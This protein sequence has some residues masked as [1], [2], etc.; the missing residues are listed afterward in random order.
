MNQPTSSF[1][2]N[3]NL[4]PYT[5]GVKA[6]AKDDPNS[7][8]QD[9]D[10]RFDMPVKELE[11]RR[12]RAVRYP[13]QLERTVRKRVARPETHGK[14]CGDRTQ[15]HYERTVRERVARPG[16]QGGGGECVRVHQYTM[17]VQSGNEWPG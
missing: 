3:F 11:L 6:P 8:W 4:R 5:E 16:T 17:R 1:I 13:V 7:V 9:R 2:Y 14:G 15:V 12:G 10:I